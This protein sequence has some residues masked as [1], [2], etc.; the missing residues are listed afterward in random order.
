MS[1]PT[2]SIETSPSTI[3]QISLTKRQEVRALFAYEG[4]VGRHTTEHSPTNSFTNL[5]KIRRVKKQ[6]HENRSLLSRGR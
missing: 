1:S 6:L 4:G 3:E 5:V 2:V